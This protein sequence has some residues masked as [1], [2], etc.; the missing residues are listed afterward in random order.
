MPDGTFLHINIFMP[1]YENSLVTSFVSNMFHV[2]LP[3][4][5]A[6]PIPLF[7]ISWSVVQL[8]QPGSQTNVDCQKV[9]IQDFFFFFLCYWF[10]RLKNKKFA[11]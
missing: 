9:P 8:T 4:V 3:P 5:I 1:Q 6:D 10:G 7:A 2:T 11:L